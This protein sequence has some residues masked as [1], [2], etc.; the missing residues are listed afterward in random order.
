M[1]FPFVGKTTCGCLS[2]STFLRFAW[3]TSKAR[4]RKSI[5]MGCLLL[6][7]GNTMFSL[8]SHCCLEWE[9]CKQRLP[10]WRWI[11][12]AD[13][14]VIH[15]FSYCSF[16][17]HYEFLLVSYHLFCPPW[18]CPEAAKDPEGPAYE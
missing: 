13:Y 8:L 7:D 4:I 1:L 5:W 18:W 16:D 11:P 9:E 14:Y 10:Q 2:G 3:L 6:T 17:S 12:S 15:C